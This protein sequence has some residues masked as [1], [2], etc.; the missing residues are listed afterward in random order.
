MLVILAAFEYA[1]PGDD[2][3]QAG[4]LWL[5]VPLSVLLIVPLAWRRRMPLP[6]F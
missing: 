1:S 3:H 2:G 4:S 5:N 6:T